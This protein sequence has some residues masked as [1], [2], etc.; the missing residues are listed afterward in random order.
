[1]TCFISKFTVLSV[2][3]FIFFVFSFEADAQDRLVVDQEIC[4]QSGK[5][6]S[7]VKKR[8]R[9]GTSHRFRLKAR[10]GQIMSV[11]L[12]TGKQTSFTIFAPAD[13]IIEGADG[14]TKWSGRLTK[15]GEYLII[16]GT[17]ISANYSLEVRIK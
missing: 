7:L 6:M 9:K 15:T 14:E 3:L 11:I 8:I 12:K 1:M 13:G 4:F 17:D 10:K 16:I 5:N 2:F